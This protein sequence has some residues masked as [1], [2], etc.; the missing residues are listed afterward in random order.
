MVFLLSFQ[1]FDYFFNIFVCFS[2]V[3]FFL[4]AGVKTCLKKTGCRSSVCNTD[5]PIFWV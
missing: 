5:C 1:V 4:S 2:G 3:V